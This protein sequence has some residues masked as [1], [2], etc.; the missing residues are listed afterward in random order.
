MDAQLK[1]DWLDTLGEGLGNKQGCAEEIKAG[2][3]DTKTREFEAVASTN[4]VDRDSEI[5]D[6]AA[7]K[8]HL[9][10]FKSN[11][12]MLWSHD[13]FRPLIGIWPKIAIQKTKI[14]V[15]GR[16]RPEGDDPMADNVASAIAAGFLKTVSIGF[17]VF[18]REPA[19]YDDEGE[20]KKPA[21]ITKAALYEISTVN[22]PSNVDAAIRTAKFLAADV[23]EKEVVKTVFAP[24]PTDAQIL[25]RAGAIL[26]RLGEEQLGGKEHQEEVLQAL[27]ELRELVVGLADQERVDFGRLRA[28]RGLTRDVRRLTG[29]S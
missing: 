21:R 8:E 12:V 10:E 23:F 16:L 15:T 9:D 6:P 26:R 2:S 4:R 11:P 17:R 5:V 3:F 27:K 14:P 22:V 18:E 7:F 19:E 24:A 25:K 29:A 20:L 1:T 13:P 28:L